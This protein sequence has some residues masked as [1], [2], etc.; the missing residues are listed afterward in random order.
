MVPRARAATVLLP[1]SASSPPTGDAMHYGAHFSLVAW[2][3]LGGGEQLDLNVLLK[4]P[5][6]QFILRN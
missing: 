5:L 3:L 2:K 1:A 6:L 4:H